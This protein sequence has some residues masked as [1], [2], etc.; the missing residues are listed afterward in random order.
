MGTPNKMRK[1]FR[2]RDVAESPVFTEGDI[3]Y[4]HYDGHYHVSKLLKHEKPFG[5]YHVLRYEPVKKQPVLEDVAGLKV[6]IYHVPMSEIAYRA[7]KWLGKLAVTPDDL[8][9]LQEYQR[10]T[11]RR[12]E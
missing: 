9:G 11:G 5:I 2:Q 6:K 3:F 10:Q 1:S 8:I 4:T 7:A 12:M